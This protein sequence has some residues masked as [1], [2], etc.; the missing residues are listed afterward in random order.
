MRQRALQEEFQAN[1]QAIAQKYF[2]KDNGKVVLHC[3]MGIVRFCD[4]GEQV[5]HGKD[6]NHPLYDTCVRALYE[7][8][9]AW[10]E[11]VAN[12]RKLEKQAALDV[13]HA[14][15]KDDPDI[16]EVYDGKIIR[17]HCDGFNLSQLDVTKFPRI[18][19]TFLF[20]GNAKRI[21]HFMYPED[22]H[23]KFS[24]QPFYETVTRILDNHDDLKMKRAQELFRELN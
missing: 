12:K 17:F 5:Q 1:A 7:C 15:F 13:A 8:S 10:D 20:N 4:T 18:L 21:I 2:G 19:L 22:W 9:L 14:L 16:Y 23:M 11:Y 6:L 3:E 24:D